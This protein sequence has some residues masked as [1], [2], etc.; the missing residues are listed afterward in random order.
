M[1]SA[2]GS[3]AMG[4]RPRYHGMG[5]ALGTGRVQEA[6]YRAQEGY[7]ATRTLYIGPYGHIGSCT[8]GRPTS[9]RRPGRSRRPHRG[10]R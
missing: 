6:V 7:M 2:P 9:S 4:V 1:G 10:R 8:G 3:Y 5:S